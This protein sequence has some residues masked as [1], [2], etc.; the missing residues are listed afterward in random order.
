VVR[1]RPPF[2]REYLAPSCRAL[3]GRDY[4]LSKH[5]MDASGEQ[6]SFEAV[7]RK[8]GTDHALHRAESSFSSCLDNTLA[9]A[10]KANGPERVIYAARKHTMNEN[11]DAMEKFFIVGSDGS[12]SDAF[13][14]SSAVGMLLRIGEDVKIPLAGGSVS[15]WIEAADGV[16]LT[17]KLVVERRVNAA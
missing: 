16:P 4:P 12:R 9:H 5:A 1:R 10:R 2:E 14:F 8:S 11:E 15:Y 3:S 17:G 7:L 13:E 6:E